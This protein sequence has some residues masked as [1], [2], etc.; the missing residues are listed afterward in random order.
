M[1]GRHSAMLRPTRARQGSSRRGAS[2]V[3]GARRAAQEGRERAVGKPVVAR[4]QAKVQA[5]FAGRDVDKV[6]RRLF[7]KTRESSTKI[8]QSSRVTNRRVHHRLAV[9]DGHPQRASTDRLCLTSAMLDART[10]R[11]F[12]NA[13]RV[14]SRPA[15]PWRSASDACRGPHPPRRP[16]P[17]S[18]GASAITLPPPRATRASAAASTSAVSTLPTR[19]KAGIGGEKRQEVA[20]DR[21]ATRHH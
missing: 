8:Y 13:G 7:S 16:R 10:R 1:R 3:R 4:E 15:M 21:D 12:L 20:V 5:G 17:S 18:T 19:R 9:S 14:T 2:E 6:G 11:R